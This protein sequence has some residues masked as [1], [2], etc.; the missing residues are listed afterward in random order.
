VQGRALPLL[1]A[2]HPDDETI[3]A[4][5][6]MAYL[7]GCAILHVTA[8]APRERRLYPV[9]FT[10]TAEQYA[11]ARRAE[12]EEALGLA[13]VRPAQIS[14]LGATDGEVALDLPRLIE[15]LAAVLT[16]AEPA[17]IITHPYEGGHPDHDATA[18]IVHAA[19]SLLRRRGRG[20]PLILEMTSYHMAKGDLSTG[21]FLDKHAGGPIFSFVLPRADRLR[22][23]RM[24]SCFRTQRRTLAPFSADVERFRVAPRY[25]FSRPP[26]PGPL[27][28]ERLGFPL[29][30]ERFRA[31]ARKALAPIVGRTLCL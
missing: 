26:H 6:T 15:A 3:G 23:E 18:L 19:S 25:D 7:S 29:T 16:K 5:A 12:V 24:L 14:T 17:V 28:Y 1:V 20:E 10:G 21:E 11:R 2:A 22:K 9:D 31:L 13:G 4:G 30:G 8:G 27:Y